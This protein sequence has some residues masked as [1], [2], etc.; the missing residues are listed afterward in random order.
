MKTYIEEMEFKLNHTNWTEQFEIIEALKEERESCKRIL[1]EYHN[2]E[3][4]IWVEC[5][6]ICE[7]E[8]EIIEHINNILN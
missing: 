3:E 4:R 6:E 5:K 1:E 8:K 7:H 2:R